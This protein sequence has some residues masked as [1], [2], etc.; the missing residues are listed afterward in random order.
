LCSMA[1]TIYCPSFAT[2]S[3]PTTHKEGPMQA[4]VSLLRRFSQFLL[5]TCLIAIALLLPSLVC[6]QAYFGTVSGELTDASGAV[7]QGASVMLSDE[8]KGF[9]FVTT[10]DASGRYLFRS[11]APGLYSITAEAKGFTKAVSSPF[12]VDLEGR[13]RE[14]DRRGWSAIA[15]YS[16]R[17]CGDWASGESQIHQRSAAD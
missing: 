1:A 16:D 12:R 17:G 13:G 2:V 14:P 15:D 11:V 3:V 9:N 6:A 5:I 4:S 8:E 7:I 10:S